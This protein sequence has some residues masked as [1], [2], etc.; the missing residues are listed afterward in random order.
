M[1]PVGEVNK[2][3]VAEVTRTAG[4][5][6]AELPLEKNV[7]NTVERASAC[8]DATERGI[9]HYGH[10]YKGPAHLLI[11][12]QGQPITRKKV[13]SEGG[14]SRDRLH[15]IIYDNYKYMI[16]M[17]N[18]NNY[19]ELQMMQSSSIKIKEK[20]GFEKQVV[21]EVSASDVLF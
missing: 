10:E 15:Q 14:P 1:L 6:H 13:E 4:V 5:Q 7:V 18:A 17:F 19:F 16:I 3:F 9:C 12:P 2:N 8:S 21:F 20:Y 11:Q